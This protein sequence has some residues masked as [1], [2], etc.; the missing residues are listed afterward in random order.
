MISGKKLEGGAEPSLKP[1]NDSVLIDPHNKKAIRQMIFRLA[2][3]SL[4]EMLLLNVTQML[5]M[6]LVGR[7][8]A[9]AVAT[10]GLTSQPYMLMM[11]L[12]AALNTGTTVIVARSSGAGNR[13]EANCA[14]GQSLLFGSILSVIVVSFTFL[15]SDVLLRVMGANEEVIQ[16]GLPYARIIFLSIGFSSISSTLSAILRGAGDTQTPMKINVFSGVLSIALAFVLIYGQL[17]FPEMGVTG[18]A[19]ATL[20]AQALTL[21]CLVVVMF[22]GRFA[23]RIRW[24]DVTQVHKSVMARMLKIGIPSSIEQLI[25]RLGIMTVVKICAGLGTVSLAANQLVTSIIGMSFMPGFAFAVAAST[26]V[27]QTLG[28]RNIELAEMYVWQIRKYGMWIGGVMGASFVLLAP[29]ILSLYTGD[30]A[31]ILE[32]TWALRIIGLIQISQI[33]Q[34]VLGG[35]LRGAGDTRFPLV[36][37]LIG[38]WGVRVVLS[39][40][41]V[42]GFGW[43]II[44]L[45]IAIAI[46]QFV[47]SMLIYWRFQRGAWKKIKI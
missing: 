27:G 37:T 44:G 8:G 5:L 4:A 26:L 6:I 42:Y 20:F 43:G 24:E 31:I 35:G 16:Y 29:N 15:Y 17:G 25:M 40:L 18:A 12:F 22:S 33:S 36:S 47:R 2:G 1:L 45:Y 46:D 30:Q 32:G 38:V 34:F 39:Y 19:F 11:V 13:E 3:P 28:V 41:L 7:L 23:V 10:V 21:I 14:A 9:A